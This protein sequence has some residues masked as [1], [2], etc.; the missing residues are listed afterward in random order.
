MVEISP[1]YHFYFRRA[2]GYLLTLL[3]AVTINFVLPRLRDTGPVDA[4]MARTSLHGMS[5]EDISQKRIELEERFDLDK[6]I[7]KQ[8]AIYV[9]QVLT[10]DFGYS[11][12]KYPQKVWD[13]V[14]SNMVWTLA[15][16]IP[17][18]ILGYLLGNILGAIA[19]YKR[20]GYD[21][22]LYPITLFFSAVP[23]FC[24]ALI[25]VY[26]FGIKL[27]WFP[28]MGGYSDLVGFG[29]NWAFISSAIY[30]YVLPFSALLLVLMGGQAIGMRSMSIYELET[31]YVN[32]AKALGVSDRRIVKYVFRN[33]MLPQLT[34]I[35]LALGLM[36]GGSLL[37]EIIF[38]Y[39]GIGAAMF[40]AVKSND[41]P[42]IQAGALLVTINVLFFNLVVDLLIAKFDPRVKSSLEAEAR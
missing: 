31:D 4:V 21:K 12:T 18:I 42:V 35:A 1:V 9:K 20:S 14:K 7:W 29:F 32:Y 2:I 5:Q 3:I 40:T 34:G 41:Y 33:A 19:A 15:L 13:L 11:V 30:H 36:V 17:A 26:I 28:P 39:P 16:Q 37:I 10:L 8:Y 38:S 27:E 23:Y 22:V 6:P 25:L 24:L